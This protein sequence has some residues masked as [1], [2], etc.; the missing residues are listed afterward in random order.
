MRQ[1]MRCIY[2]YIY[3]WHSEAFPWGLR[4]A[5]RYIYIY[6]CDLAAFFA[7]GYAPHIYIYI[8]IYAI[9]AVADV[10]TGGSPLFQDDRIKIRGH[11]YIYISFYFCLLAYVSMFAYG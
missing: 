11:I 2:I 4:Q 6:I 1:G 8:Y 7:P 10:V 3:I 9:S 5:M